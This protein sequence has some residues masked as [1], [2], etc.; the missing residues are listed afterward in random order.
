MACH[1][2]ANEAFAQGEVDAQLRPER[3]NVLSHALSSSW[4]GTARRTTGY[5]AGL[6]LRDAHFGMAE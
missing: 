2:V 1:A 4:P 6:D 3:S 5:R